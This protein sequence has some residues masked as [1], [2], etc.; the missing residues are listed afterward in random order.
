M[1][2]IIKKKEHEQ[3]ESLRLSRNLVT[4]KLFNVN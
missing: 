1:T 4:W 2:Q 3:K